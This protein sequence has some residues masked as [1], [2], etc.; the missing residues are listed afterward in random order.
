MVFLTV[1]SCSFVFFQGLILSKAL[2]AQKNAEDERCK[3]ALGNLC[4]E[5]ISLR[6]EALEKDRILLSLVEK[7]KSSEASL[8]TE[9]EAHR[10][11][12]EEIKKKVVEATE[13]FEVEVVKHE[14]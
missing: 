7:L 4:S 11:E 12:V 13:K 1:I 9:A 6:N 3:I 5:V 14:I 2:K 10:A 8:A